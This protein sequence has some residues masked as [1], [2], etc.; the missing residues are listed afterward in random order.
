MYIFAIA[1]ERGTAG[2]REKEMKSG[3]DGTEMEVL[4]FSRGRD[5]R[6][7]RSGAPT[8]ALPAQRER[9]KNRVPHF[10]VRARVRGLAAALQPTQFCTNQIFVP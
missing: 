6:G 4:I 2:G 7:R 5:G 10:R 3:E 9:E 8:F 1:T